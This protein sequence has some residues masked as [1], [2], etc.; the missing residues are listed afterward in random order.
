MKRKVLVIG[1]AG[2]I[3]N[4]ITRALL[5]RGC[6]VTAVGRRVQQPLNLEGL[7]LTYKAGDADLPGQFEQWIHGC[8]LVVDAA[9]P[10]PLE[11][12][13]LFKTEL[14]PVAGAEKRTA[15][16]IK[17]VLKE[18]AE[19][20]HIGSFVTCLRPR[21]ATQRLQASLA[22]IT[23]PYFEI[24]SL[25]ETQLLDAARHGLR[26]VIV[27]PTYCMGP[28]D[29]HDRQLCVIP[30]LLGGEM[31]V[32]TRQRLNIIDTR[33]VA[34]AALS[35]AELGRYAEPIVLTGHDVRT[36]ELHTLICSSSGVTVR[37]LTIP[38]ALAAVAAYWL[39][40]AQLMSTIMMADMFEYLPNNDDLRALGLEARPL[41]DTVRDAT[42]WYRRIG[43]C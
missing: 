11:G 30:L 21:S 40:T 34:L 3:G 36:D 14:T 2:H 4:A 13:S 5:D 43:Y 24:K 9:A 42:A 6:E 12:F 27:N 18:D 10:Y 41:A 26:V 22:R 32:T 8:D 15:R 33:D 1:A 37:T 39:D 31:R 20:I 16:L 17:A 25:I 29:L 35:A 7:N 19:L 38:S 28:W 23:H